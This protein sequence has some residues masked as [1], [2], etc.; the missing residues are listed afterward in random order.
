MTKYKR[1]ILNYWPFP[2]F[3]GNQSSLLLSIEKALPTTDVIVI[4]APMAAGKSGISQTIARYLNN[5]AVI[6][7]TNTLLNQFLE[8]FPRFP[9]LHK[10]ESYVCPW[11]KEERLTCKYVSTKH[12]NKVK[13]VDCEYIK[14]KKLAHTKYI[15][16]YNYYTYLSMKLYHQNLIIDEATEILG[17]LQD[18]AAKRFWQRDVKYPNWVYS[19]NDIMDWVMGLDNPSPKHIELLNVVTAEKQLSLLERGVEI[20]RGEKEDLLK[21]SPLSV[22]E[23]PPILWPPHRTKKIILLSATINQI[24]IKELGLDK[25]RRVI[26]FE[27]DSA[28]PVNRKPL[29]CDF[30]GKFNYSN[31]D[32]Y[33]PKLVEKIN[34]IQESQNERGFIHTTYALAKKLKKHLDPS[35]YLFH[36]K[37]DSFYKFNMWKSGTL[38]HKVFVGCGFEKGIDL[39]GDEFTWQIITKIQFPSLADTAIKYRVTEMGDYGTKWYIW[40]TLKEVMQACGRICRG[41]EDYGETWILDGNFDNLIERAAELNLIPK[42]FNEMLFPASASIPEC[43]TEKDIYDTIEF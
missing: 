29:I 3:R 43:I 42:W 7:P 32:K 40:K 36:S 10:K 18:L 22:E 6:F 25:D 13:C 41:P 20:L 27:M 17:M 19:Y 5:T 30:V 31:I 9:K 4:V 24:D 26:Y 37:E 35:I 34:K 11:F 8:S 23:H 15:G 16:A 14:D 2:E 12:K 1:S 38:P 39:A 28:I 33:V 21:M